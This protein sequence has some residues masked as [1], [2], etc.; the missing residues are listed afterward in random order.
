MR[1]GV[2]LV[3]TASLWS[4]ACRRAEPADP[5]VVAEWMRALYGTIR[6]ERLSPP[7]ASRLMAYSTT[8]L[9]AGYVAGDPS[10]PPLAGALNELPSLPRAARPGDLDGARVALEAVRVLL[11]SLLVEALPTTRAALARLSDSLRTARA[12]AGGF[13]VSDAV[14]VRSDSVGGVI[15]RAIVAWARSD[16]FSRTRTLPPYRPPSGPAF[17]ANDAPATTFASQS[18]SGASELITP[19]N[20]ANQLRDA[21]TSDR[22][23]VL[24]RPKRAGATSLPAVNMAGASEPYW[25]QLRPFVLERWDACPL[26]P[27]PPYSTERSSVLRTNAQEVVDAKASLTA[28]QRTIALYWADNAGESGTP[29]GHWT[30]IASQMVS[31]RDLS[32]AEAA[33]VVMLTAVAQA[34][35]FIASWGYKYTHNLLRPR[36]YIRRVID[37]EWEPLIPT[38]PFPEYP[39]GHST[40][41]AAAATTLAGVLGDGAFDDSTSISIGHAVRRFP[42]FMAA[43]EEAGMSRIYGGIHFDV[44]N[45]SGRDLGICI[46]QRVL[47]RAASQQPSTAR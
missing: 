10:L 11:D 27:P 36:M 8:A 31:Q 47:A 7:V 5:R 21:N 33:R 16:G 1:I 15:G 20:P 35:A 3:L 17:W 43:A 32:A 22:A 19:A 44:G 37:P 6:V 12:A 9:Y 40:Q 14:V 42:S 41:S 30:S 34:D 46:G 2:T 4:G 24:G 39:S 26:A 13:G 28:E 18:I 23:L 38:P 29:V 25:G 45:R